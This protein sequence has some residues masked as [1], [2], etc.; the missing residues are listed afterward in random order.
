M[1]SV[2]LY[3]NRFVILNDALVCF[4]QF[5]CNIYFSVLAKAMEGID[6]IVGTMAD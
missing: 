3:E 2:E 1:S 5:L 6:D 4:I